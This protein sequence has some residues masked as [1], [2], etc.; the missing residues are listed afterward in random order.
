MRDPGKPGSRPGPKGTKNLTT[1][2]NNV[3]VD[4]LGNGLRR[5]NPAEDLGLRSGDEGAVRSR[6]SSGVRPRPVA[7]VL[8]RSGRLRPRRRLR[9]DTEFRVIQLTPEGASTSIQFGV[10]LTDAP[11]G[12]LRGLYLVVPDI[13]ASRRELAE[14]GV[15]VSEVRHKDTGGGG[16]QGAYV[17]HL[18]SGPA[19]YATFADFAIP[20]AMPGFFKSAVTAEPMISR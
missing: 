11:V 13:E 17:P 3:G 12:S 19:D 20:T 9:A 14:R 2:S 15:D 6:H 16:W 8:P 18:Y 4:G 5:R 7:A 10:G 1:I